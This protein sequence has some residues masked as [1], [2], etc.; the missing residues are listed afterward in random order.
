MRKTK[1]VFKGSEVKKLIADSKTATF[2]TIPYVGNRQDVPVGLILVKDDGIYLISN[3]VRAETP[4]ASGLIA[5]AKGYEAPSKL[6][7]DERGEQ[8]EKIRD[9]AGGD[10]FAEAITI[11]EST[12]RMLLDG[13]DFILYLMPDKITMQ[14]RRAA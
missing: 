7:D 9:A 12:A 4:S 3:A 10:D 11:S 5:Y 14:I 2:R 6:A 13:M 1:L 8:Y